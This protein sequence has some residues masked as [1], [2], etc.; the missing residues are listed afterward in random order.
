[1]ERHWLLVKLENFSMELVPL[2]F[3]PGIDYMARPPE[4]GMC[5]PP[6]NRYKFQTFF[7]VHMAVYVFASS[8]CD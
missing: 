1:M 6:V 3:Q 4:S 2:Q 8:E 5:I 7:S